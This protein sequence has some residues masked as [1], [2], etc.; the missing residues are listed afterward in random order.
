M[1]RAYGTTRPDI[2]EVFGGHAEVSLQGWRQGWLALQP[3]DQVYGDDLSV[4]EERREL[5]RIQERTRP[6]LVLIEFPC[7]F[8]SQLARTNYHRSNAGRQKFTVQ[9]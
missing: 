3:I 8:W 9:L 2:W 6:R 1:Q 5:L 7:T 4:Y